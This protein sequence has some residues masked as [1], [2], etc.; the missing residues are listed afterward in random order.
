MSRLGMKNVVARAIVDTD[1]RKKAFGDG[2]DLKGAATASGYD[3]TDD[4][5]A[6]LSC[7]NEQSF[8]E[9]FVTIDNMMDFWRLSENRIN[10]LVA[11]RKA[12]AGPLPQI[13]SP[14]ALAEGF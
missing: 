2:A 7:N 11:G 5:L 4:E 14:A 8:S 9:E 10:N 12:E 1:F 6:M 13:G 3:V